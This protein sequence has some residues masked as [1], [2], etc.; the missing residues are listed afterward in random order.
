M[1]FSNNL[2]KNLSFKQNLLKKPV[3]NLPFSDAS[4]L[5]PVTLLKQMNPFLPSF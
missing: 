2:F 3:V 4:G 1:I 5:K